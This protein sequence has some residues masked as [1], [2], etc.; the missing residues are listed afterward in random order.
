MVTRVRPHP[1]KDTST[2]AVMVPNELCDKHTTELVP[3]E[4]DQPMRVIS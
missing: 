2:G 1:K 4:R 3:V